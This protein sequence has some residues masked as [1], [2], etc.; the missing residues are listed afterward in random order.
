MLQRRMDKTF[1]PRELRRVEHNPWALGLVSVPLVAT[2]AALAGGGEGAL[3]AVFIC[4]LALFYTWRT[5]P[6][7]RL[8]PVTA[9][10]DAGGLWIGERCL[11]RAAIREAFVIPPA[12][13]VSARVRVVPAGARP[14]VEL[15]VADLAEGRR[16]LQALGRDTAQT[17]A[18]FRARSRMSA[19]PRLAAL[20]AAAVLGVTLLGGVVDKIVSAGSAGGFLFLLGLAAVTGL[21]LL[22]STLVI[23]ADGVSLRWLRW[24][25]FVDFAEVASI[26]RFG[27]SMGSKATGVAL[28]LRS[29][30]RVR[31]ALGTQGW[32]AQHLATVEMRLHQAFVTWQRGGDVADE[33]KLRR[34]ERSVGAWVNALRAM[35]A[36]ADA[37]PRTAPVPRDRLWSIVEDPRADLAVRAAAAVALGGTAAGEDRDRLRVA[38]GV[39]AAPKLRIAIEAA[40]SEDDA[41]VEEALAALAQERDERAGDASR[42]AL[43]RSD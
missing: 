12:R 34:G 11:P 41:A 37:G 8:R 26:E 19:S 6:W 32:D 9:R 33:A 38:A 13:R 17:A 18:R 29:G 3:R 28:V 23:G 27:P 30:E 1:G 2:L 10:V 24:S 16:L 21:Y 25:R 15:E 14:S 4:G 20:S 22:P 7:A 40:A 35:G 5:K 43:G 39:T 31:I 42:V 36:G